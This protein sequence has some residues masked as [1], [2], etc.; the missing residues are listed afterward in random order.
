MKRKILTYSLFILLGSCATISKVAPPFTN[1]EKISKLKMGTTLSV[2]SSTLDIPPYNILSM[3]EDGSG[4]YAFNYRL[5]VR[6]TSVPEGKE[7]E[8]LL[9]SEQYNTAGEEKYEDEIK[10]VITVFKEGK[11]SAI[12]TT[13][14]W[15]KAEYLMIVDNNLKLL[16]KQDLVKLG[17]LNKG[18]LIKLNK[19]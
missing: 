7:G 13:E 9:H 14:G 11:L 10:T 3:Q 4:I 12:H 15:E 16:T 8:N 6:K 1:V 18:Q 2:V 19:N 5:K 17:V